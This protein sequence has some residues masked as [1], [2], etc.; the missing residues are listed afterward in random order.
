[1]SIYNPRVDFAFKKLFASD[2]LSL[3]ALIN[4]ILPEDE[5]LTQVTLLNPFN[6]RSFSKDKLSV[7]DI[8]AMD[9][10]GRYYNIEMQITDEVCY[11]QRVLYYW[12]K[13]YSGQLKKGEG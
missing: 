7:L 4:A 5:H 8:Q 9:A 3:T 11:S 1:M 12:S 6:E 2:L 13:L 10:L